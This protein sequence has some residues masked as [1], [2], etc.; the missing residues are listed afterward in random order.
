MARRLWLGA[1]LG[2]LVLGSAGWWW[3]Q[4][5][6]TVQMVHP[7]RKNLVELVVATGMYRA[8]HQSTI[9]A[10]VSGVLA[11]VNVQAGDRVVAGQVLATL[12]AE[13]EAAATARAQRAVDTARAA[14]AVAERGPLPAERIRAEA[15]R[16]QAQAQLSQ[17]RADLVRTEQL[18]A[19]HLLAPAELD[20]ART[21]VATAHAEYDVAAS[22]CAILAAQPHPEDVHLARAQLREAET[23][24]QQAQASARRRVVRAPWSGLIIRRLSEPGQ[25]VAPGTPLAVLAQT[26]RMEIYLETDENNLAR[27]HPGLSATA[28][29]PAYPRNPFPA[30]V[31]QVGPD[32]DSSRGTVPVRLTVPS[33]PAFLRPEMTLDVSIVTQRLP[34]ALTVPASAVI[35]SDGHATVTVLQDG[36][37]VRQPVRI[38][39]RDLDRVAL[40]GLPESMWVVRQATEVEPGQTARAASH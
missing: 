8:I 4:P 31:T 35:D 11:T 32:L 19:E 26:D 30:T 34:Q 33:P 6:K 25:S 29:S 2:I 23:A 18:A 27:L 16:N 39:G 3:A 37:A 14:L 5:R 20:R 9:G 10:E 1:A 13:D 15:R 7:E 40:T 21:A 22:E 28:V 24:L 12:L 38:L 17:A 36:R